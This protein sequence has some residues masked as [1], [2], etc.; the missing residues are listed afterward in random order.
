MVPTDDGEEIVM[1]VMI[2]VMVVLIMV[3][4]MVVIL[5]MVIMMAKAKCCADTGG[6]ALYIHYMFLFR[7]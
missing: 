2:I 6:G 5:V 1:V 3:L 4:I 7:C